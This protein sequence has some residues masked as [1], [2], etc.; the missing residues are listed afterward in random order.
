MLDSGPDEPQA[1]GIFCRQ[2][3]RFSKIAF[4][5]QLEPFAKRPKR[6]GFSKFQ[7]PFGSF[8]N[9]VHKCA[10]AFR[11]RPNSFFAILFLDAGTL[12]QF[13][14]TEAASL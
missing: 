3:T 2:L 6:I 12:Q 11:F 13:P 9:G 10:V 1:P 7:M 4:F 14:K 8:F 5:S